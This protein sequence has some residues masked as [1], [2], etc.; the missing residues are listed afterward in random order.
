MLL[1]TIP[2][3]SS[4]FHAPLHHSILLFTIPCSS[5]PFHAPLHHFMLLFTIPC[6]SSPFHAPLHHFMLLFTI[7]CSSSPF[8]APLHHSMLI[9]SIQKEMAVGYMPD[10]SKAILYDLGWNSPCGQMYSTTSDLDKVRQIKII[11][12]INK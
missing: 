7:P 6:S 12:L 2:Y 9:C 10:G 1:F 11:F 5:S 8:H 3:S 4:P